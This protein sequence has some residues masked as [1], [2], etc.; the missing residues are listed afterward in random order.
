MF[1]FSPYNLKLFKF[2]I[3][4]VNFNFTLDSLKCD[5]ILSGI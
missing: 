4:K 5:V 2:Q 1:L 3:S